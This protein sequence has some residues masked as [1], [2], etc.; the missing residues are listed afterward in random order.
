MT[1]VATIAMLS[2]S[3]SVFAQTMAGGYPQ[4][5]SGNEICLNTGTACYVDIVAHPTRIRAATLQA[6]NLGIRVNSLQE[7]SNRERQLVD[8][9]GPGGFGQYGLSDPCVTKVL[10]GLTCEAGEVS[11]T[12]CR[13]QNNEMVTAAYMLAP[14]PQPTYSAPAPYVAPVQ[15]VVYQPQEQCKRTLDGGCFTG[16]QAFVSLEKSRLKTYA[17]QEAGLVYQRGTAILQKLT[18]SIQFGVNYQL[19]PARY[20]NVTSNV[21]DITNPGTNPPPNPGP[22]NPAPDNPGGTPANP[23]ADNPA[24]DNP[25]GTP[26]NPPTDAPVTPIPSVPDGAPDNG[27]AGPAS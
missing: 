3:S 1:S 22:D 15:Q 13:D 21:V 25:G 10:A 17:S 7:D 5:N 11:G 23:P 27:G 8:V 6:Q 24:P 14:P 16:T 12:A 9:R 19:N 18:P 26:F 4:A 20:S 2:I